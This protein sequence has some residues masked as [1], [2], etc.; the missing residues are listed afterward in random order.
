MFNEHEWVHGEFTNGFKFRYT[1]P[2]GLTT[3]YEWVEHIRRYTSND[4]EWIA[5]G[6][7]PDESAGWD[8][9]AMKL[10][11]PDTELIAVKGSELNKQHE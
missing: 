8:G 11:T 6:F 3:P 5:R 9:W 2:V 1:A 4:I 7:T 10:P